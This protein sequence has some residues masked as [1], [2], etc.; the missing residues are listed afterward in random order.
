M[1]DEDLLGPSEGSKPKSNRKPKPSD[2]GGMAAKQLK[3]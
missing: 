2:T 1:A 3:S